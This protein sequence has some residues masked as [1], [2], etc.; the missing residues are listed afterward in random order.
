MASSDEKTSF[1]G[2]ITDLIGLDQ[3]CFCIKS[4]CK[5]YYNIICTMVHGLLVARH[6]YS[7]FF[8]FIISFSHLNQS[9]TIFISIILK[10]Y[11]AIHNNMATFV[12]CFENISAKLLYF[13]KQILSEFSFVCR[14]YDLFTVFKN[15]YFLIE[16]FLVILFIL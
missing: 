8:V 4:N 9:S 1:L 11:I 5:I 3:I 15:N 13:Y 10:F 7:L 12:N 2:N 14:T 16:V 6:C